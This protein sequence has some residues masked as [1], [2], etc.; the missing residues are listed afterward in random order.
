MAF[1]VSGQAIRAQ[2]ANPAAACLDRGLTRLDIGRGRLGS[3][4]FSVPLAGRRIAPS[5]P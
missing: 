2:S 1:V 5:G 4:V 3:G